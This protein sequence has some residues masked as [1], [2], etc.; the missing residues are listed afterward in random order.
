M[1]N[2]EQE[3]YSAWLAAETMHSGISEQEEGRILERSRLAYEKAYDELGSAW[4]SIIIRKAKA[5]AG[6]D[7]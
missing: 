5:A 4:T 6:D 1:L 7:I 3:L 2:V